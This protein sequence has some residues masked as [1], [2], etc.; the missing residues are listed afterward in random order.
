MRKSR[1]VQVGQSRKKKREG[2]GENVEWW[3]NQISMKE[4]VKKA[5]GRE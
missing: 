3:V 2:K 5:K 4:R 1:V